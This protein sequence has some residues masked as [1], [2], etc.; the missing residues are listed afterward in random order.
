[1]PIDSG[2]K[3]Q[4]LIFKGYFFLII[5]LRGGGGGIPAVPVEN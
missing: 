1:M 2:A 4:H 3:A 5:N